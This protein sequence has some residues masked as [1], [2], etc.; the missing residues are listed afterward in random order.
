MYPHAE[1]MAKEIE[2]SQGGI[3]KIM[4]IGVFKGYLIKAILKRYHD[5]ISEYWGVDPW[6]PMHSQWRRDSVRPEVWNKHYFYV[7]RL[8]RFF[9]KLHIIR[10]TSAQAAPL[11]PEGYFDLVFIDGCHFYKE[12]LDDIKNYLPLVR[13]GGIL[14]GH[15]YTN[16]KGEIEV[17]KA[18]DEFFVNEILEIIE[19]PEEQRKKG[20]NPGL[21]TIW[22]YRKD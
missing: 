22:V 15:D 14:S 19:I 8:M 6:V 5:N 7:A 13:K 20:K 9:P 3:Q 11:F 17:K 12:V 16:I 1:W 4:E 21:S 2:K 10:S 18:V